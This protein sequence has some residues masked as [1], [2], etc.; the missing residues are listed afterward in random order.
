[1]EL[2][3]AAKVAELEG[4]WPTNVKAVCL[5][6]KSREKLLGYLVFIVLFGVFFTK[7]V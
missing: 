5:Y 2:R 6:S 3:L 4:A 7:R 1:M